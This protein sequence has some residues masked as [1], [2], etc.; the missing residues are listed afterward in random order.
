MIRCMILTLIVGTFSPIVA[1]AAIVPPIPRLPIGFLNPPAPQPMDST[2]M[3]PDDPASLADRITRN[4]HSAGE[5]LAAAD[6]GDQTRRTQDAILKDIDKLL[7]L[8]DNPPPSGGGGGGGSAGM[9]PPMGNS[10]PTGGKSNNGESPSSPPKGRNAPRS[11]N[12]SGNPANPQTR[13]ESRSSSSGSSSQPQAD[14]N[15]QAGGPTPSQKTGWRNRDQQKQAHQ[16]PG[17]GERKPMGSQQLA[18]QNPKPKPM[19]RQP[20]PDAGSP[21]PVAQG[22]QTPSGSG[23]R[24]KASATPAPPLDDPYTKQVWGHLPEQMRQ[25]MTQ[26]YREQFVSKYGDLLRQYYSSLAEREK[27]GGKR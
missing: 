21:T 25:K 24:G 7:Q 10:D 4:T 26:Y 15:A 22:P 3:P 2:E 6:P 9:P 12:P 1:H 27:S 13:S 23:T 14:K 16:K 11:D 18:A 17:E 20:M 19:P 5:R 8:A